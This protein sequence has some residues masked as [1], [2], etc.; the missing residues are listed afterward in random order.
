MDIVNCT[1]R[2]TNAFSIFTALVMQEDI[3][4]SG[5]YQLGV[6][7]EVEARRYSQ[8][9]EPRFSGFRP[10]SDADHV[11][12]F[13][14]LNKAIFC[15][16]PDRLD[17]ETYVNADMLGAIH[18]SGEI[19]N[20]DIPDDGTRSAKYNE[21]ERKNIQENIIDKCSPEIASWL[22][23]LLSLFLEEKEEFGLYTV[24]CDKLSL[25]CRCLVYEKQGRGGDIRIKDTYY[26]LSKRDQ[27][28]IS[29]TGSVLAT[30][31]FL[32]NSL[33]GHPKLLTSRYF[34]IFM[35]IIQ[36]AAKQIRG[37]EIQWLNNYLTT[38]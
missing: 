28:A 31:I 11:L 7:G 30:D 26:K 6:N 38:H 34:S 23:A 9:P 24:G 35:E 14:A 32:Y 10:N 33:E 17:H 2:G 29:Y 27:E 16:Y 18:D 21:I 36:S 1:D 22:E 5:L 3:R 15:I 8:N 13:T 25:V 37:S 4:R 19:T 12:E 20:G